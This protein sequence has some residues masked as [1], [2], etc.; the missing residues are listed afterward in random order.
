MEV[1]FTELIFPAGVDDGDLSLSGTTIPPLSCPYCVQDGP[2]DS[3]GQNL[4]M[5]F[6]IVL[7]KVHFAQAL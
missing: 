6:F 2:A 1:C 5:V 7:M 3:T 4:G